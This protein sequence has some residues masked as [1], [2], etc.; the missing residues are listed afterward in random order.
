MLECPAMERADIVIVGGGAAGYFGAAAAAERAPGRRVLLLE[1]GRR[2]LAKVLVSGGGRCNV[3]HACFDPAVLV[4]SY[5]RGGDALR[6][7][8]SRFQPRDTVAWFESRGVRLKTEPDG[9]M[10]PVT[11]SSAT[12]A[13]ALRKAAADAGVQCWTEADVSEVSR[14]D[15][16]LALDLAGGARVVARRLLLA[17]GGSPRGHHW[18]RRLGHRVE[19]PVPSLFTFHV[20]GD[21]RLAGL[22]GV[23]VQN[24]RVALTGTS[25]AQEGPLLVTHEGFSG[26]AALKL[27][28]W[29]ARAFHERGYKASLEVRWVSEGNRD[30]TL[31]A[32]KSLKAAQGRQSVSS[33]PAFGL[34]RRLWERLVAVAGLEGRKWA[35]AS[36]EG[37]SRLAGELAGGAYA[38]TGKSAFKEEFV[39]CG[40]VRLDEVDFRT[41]ESRVC[42]GLHFA[43]EILDVDGVTGG[44]NFQNAW[45]TGWLAGRAMAAAVGGTAASC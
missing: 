2:G 19:T 3:T 10:F 23:A 29:G 15:D 20:S 28:A 4:K 9:R 11:D 25:L 32:L 24:A 40:G 45:T 36:G 33:H 34:P 42:P 44:F 38:M 7:P 22:A 18:A 1:K 12:I 13:D 21:P 14:A 35:D 17:T 41:L 37:L 27:S 30:A 8:F 39:T 43:G 16:G 6:G 26:P 31:A 5:P